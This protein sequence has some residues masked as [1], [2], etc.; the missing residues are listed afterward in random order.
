MAG[1]GHI[2]GAFESIYGVVPRSLSEFKA[3]GATTAH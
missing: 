1:D 2:R 3:Y